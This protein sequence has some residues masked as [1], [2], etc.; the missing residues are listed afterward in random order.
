LEATSNTHGTATG[1]IMISRSQL[2]AMREML[3]DKSDK[4]LIRLYREVTNH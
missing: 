1:Q 3:P 4:E 2:N